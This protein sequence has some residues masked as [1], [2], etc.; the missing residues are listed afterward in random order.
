ME[1]IVMNVDE[2]HDMM[3]SMMKCKETMEEEN[4][5]LQNNFV[6][7]NEEFQDAAYS[8]YE[9]EFNKGNDAILKLNEATTDIII[10]LGNYARSM[11]DKA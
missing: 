2:I 8:K 4:N 6:K 9:T 11:L 3:K 10:A 1:N 7:L 5:K